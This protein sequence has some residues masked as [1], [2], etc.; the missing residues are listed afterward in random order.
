M[1]KHFRK[2]VSPYKVY[3]ELIF[4]LH[5]HETQIGDLEKQA[6]VVFGS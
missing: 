4:S 6:M 1:K 5:A 2:S 3:G